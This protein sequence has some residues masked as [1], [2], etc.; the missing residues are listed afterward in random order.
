LK[1]S[2]KRFETGEPCA[3][4]WSKTSCERAGGNIF[5]TKSP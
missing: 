2:S 4:R 3:S 1:E 5:A